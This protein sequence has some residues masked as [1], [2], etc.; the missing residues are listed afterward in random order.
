[1]NSE[2][3]GKLFSVA[4][5][6]SREGDIQGVV[7][8]MRELVKHRPESGIFAAVLANALK[9][10]GRTDEAEHYFRNAVVLSPEREEVSLGLFHC[11][12][13]QGKREEA[14]EEMRRFVKLADRKE[15]KSILEAILKSG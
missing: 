13:G 6:R 10:L 8:T 12:W 14:L 4:Q 2:D 11:L 5:Q 7:D 9:S 1:M 15:Y 3:A